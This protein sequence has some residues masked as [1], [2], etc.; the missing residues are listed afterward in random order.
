MNILKIVTGAEQ[1]S[2]QNPILDHLHI[3]HIF[4]Y[5]WKFLNFHQPTNENISLTDF[6]KKL[7]FRKISTFPL[8]FDFLLVFCFLDLRVFALC[9]FVSF[10]RL[11]NNLTQIS[12]GSLL[13]GVSS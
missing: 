6:H 9:L 2:A 7:D 13:L 12:R 1:H 5:T 4:E 3:S 11:L 8:L 10:A